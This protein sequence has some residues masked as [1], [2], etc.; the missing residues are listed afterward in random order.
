MTAL[1]TETGYR[2]TVSIILNRL[3]FVINVHN[4]SYG[5]LASDGLATQQSNQTPFMVKDNVRRPPG[6][7]GERKSVEM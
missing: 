1:S 2:Y 6:E 7:L 5:A 4:K 3:N